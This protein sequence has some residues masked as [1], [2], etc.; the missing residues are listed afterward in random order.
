[1]TQ[2][3]LDLIIEK[4][5]QP[6]NGWTIEFLGNYNFDFF[7]NNIIK[8]NNTAVLEILNNSLPFFY[9]CVPID[10]IFYITNINKSITHRQVVIDSVYL[11]DINNNSRLTERNDKK[12]PFVKS[13]LEYRGFSG[14]YESTERY[15]ESVEYAWNKQQEKI[16]NNKNNTFTTINKKNSNNGGIYRIIS[17]DDKNNIKKNLYVGLTERD[18]KVRWQEH[19]NI[20]YGQAP[21]PDG[22]HK[23]YNL[24]KT[25]LETNR[26]IAEPVIIFNELNTNRPL[27]RG[28]KEAMELA[29]ITLLQPLGNTAGID[30]PYYFSD[31][32]KIQYLVS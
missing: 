22:M 30:V 26:I 2:D 5:V 6:A 8:V 18:F 29:T 27:S 23:L 14:Y 28:E 21:I 32:N 20:L 4:I 9:Y 16:K 25:E 10:N 31:T 19:K 17:I 3:F 1:M 12:G 13:I 24:L 15:M 11:S 7:R